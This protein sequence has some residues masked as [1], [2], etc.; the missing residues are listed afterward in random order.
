[1]TIKVEESVNISWNF[2]A[3]CSST[4]NDIALQS[5]ALDESLLH[6]IST[7]KTNPILIPVYPEINLQFIDLPH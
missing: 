7:N 4:L 2:V 3:G 1:M 5:P 6:C